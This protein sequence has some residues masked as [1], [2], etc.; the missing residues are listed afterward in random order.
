M[1]KHQS[2]HH[3]PFLSTNTP[4]NPQFIFHPSICFWERHCVLYFLIV[5]LWFSVLLLIET[6]TKC[7]TTFHSL[8]GWA[9]PTT[10]NITSSMPY[11]SSFRCLI[12]YLMPVLTFFV[13]K[14]VERLLFH[15]HISLYNMYE[16][17]YSLCL[18]LW[19]TSLSLLLLWSLH[20]A[21]SRKFLLP[22]QWRH[23]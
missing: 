19:L 3:C 9:L 23:Q 17:D 13:S 18:F 20:V 1:F 21:T 16:K 15:H 8:P 5:A 6:H 22:T 4:Q 10:K 2:L 12:S 7:F 11:S 14:V